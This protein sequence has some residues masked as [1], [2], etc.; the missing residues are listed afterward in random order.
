MGATS[1]DELPQI[2]QL[3]KAV[4]HWDHTAVATCLSDRVGTY[5]VKL[6]TRRD[7][8]YTIAK[9]YQYK[10]KASFPKRV[11]HRAIDNNHPISIFF[12]PH[13]LGNGYVFNPGQVL[14]DGIENRIN[15]TEET[16][17]VWVD[18]PIEDGVVY[19][20]YIS[21]R[22]DLPDGSYD[23]PDQLSRVD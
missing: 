22:A 14:S 13:T 17:S 2:R 5:C 3:L 8:V 12:N 9:E 21:N 6:E 1:T 23:P 10:N 7:H 15:R 16:R 4:D 18:I 20:D 11:V 19:G